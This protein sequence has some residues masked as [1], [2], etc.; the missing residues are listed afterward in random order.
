MA[1]FTDLLVN[2]LVIVLYHHSRIA[3]IESLQGGCV[4]GVSWSVLVMALPCFNTTAVTQ[5]FRFRFQPQGRGDPGQNISSVSL[6][7]G[8]TSAEERKLGGP[9]A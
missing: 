6:F 8:K 5:N 1:G 2:W 4:T 9:F 7:C 3:K